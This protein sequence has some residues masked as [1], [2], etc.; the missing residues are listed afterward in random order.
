[1]GKRKKWRNQQLMDL[2]RSTGMTYREIGKKFGIST[3]SAWNVVKR[4][5]KLEREARAAALD[6][7]DGSEE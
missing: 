1:M 3:T 4:E 5:L 6:P 2:W 7:E